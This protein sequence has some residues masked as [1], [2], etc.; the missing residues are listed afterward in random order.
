MRLLLKNAAVRG[1]ALDPENAKNSLEEERRNG[2]RK[3]RLRFIGL[4]PVPELI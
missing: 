1:Y 3:L 4:A 2:G